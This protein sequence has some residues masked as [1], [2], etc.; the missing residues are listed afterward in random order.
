[1][2]PRAESLLTDEDVLSH[3]RG[4]ANA[5]K[6]QRLWAGDTGDY[7][8]DDS[9]ADLA[10]VSIM[11]FWTQDEAQL[12][13]LFRSS[14]LYREKW[15]RADYRER[16]IAKALAGAESYS[17][18]F[19]SFPSHNGSSPQPPRVSDVPWPVLAP[20]AR[21]GLA[22]RIVE[23]FAPHTEADDAAILANVLTMFGS[24]LGRGPHL[25]VS[26]DRHGANL[27]IVLCGDTSKS[28][29]GSSQGGPRRLFSLADPG[30]ES[31]RIQGGLSS[32]EGLVWA[33]RDRVT[34]VNRRGETEVTDGGI[35]DK[36][37]LCVEEEFSAVLK[38]ASRQGC[39]VS[40]QLRRA[41]DSRASLQIM[42]KN[43]PATASHPHVSLVGHVTTQELKRVLTET[44]QAN[45]FANRI[46]WLCVKRYKIL[47]FP[48]RLSEQD[49]HALSV[50]LRHALDHGRRLSEVR[51][52]PAARERWGNV[53]GVLS[54][55][56]AG[57]FGALVAR[58]EAITLR[59]ALIFAM[60][61]RSTTVGAPHLEA[62]LA[63]WQ[64]AEDSARYIFGDATG[65]PVADRILTALRQN[66]PLTQ[67]DV[68]GL[69]GRHERADRIGAA[70]GI[71][72]DRGRIESS[73]QETDGRTVTLWYAL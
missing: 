55:G 18:S 12:D 64:Y 46:A 11:G 56:K 43:S 41:W 16:T 48:G 2:R 35:D 4:A 27:F 17:P 22:G 24:A 49:A 54:D 70:M 73:R 63:F 42:T 21:Y 29:K 13:R 61:D 62:A 45:G 10:L 40:E 15:D 36:R 47:P 5:P 67:T 20:E 66:G 57:L 31:E 1:V 9:A 7:H 44:D 14:G 28:R 33:I 3:A 60:L 23:A 32:G 59:V 51:L 50:E 53:Y 68:S 65:D 58:S 72:V 25:L 37:L 30:W 8:G 39:T 26:D 69:L 38:A 19:L 71:L 6:F 52:D 34:R